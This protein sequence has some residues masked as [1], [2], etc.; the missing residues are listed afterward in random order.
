MNGD[1]IILYG[2]CDQFRRC[3][4]VTRSGHRRVWIFC[5]RSLRIG[6]FVDPVARIFFLGDAHEQVDTLINIENN[7]T[8]HPVP[9]S[10]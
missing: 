5:R 10:T 8:P 2:T 6:V 4:Y 9:M 1:R 3:V 7:R